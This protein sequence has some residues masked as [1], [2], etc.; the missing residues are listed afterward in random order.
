MLERIF[1]RERVKYLDEQ[2]V[3]VLSKMETTE[4]SSEEYQTLITHLER[5]TKLRHGNTPE[6]LSR[7]TM[8]IVGGN[9]LL[10]FG[11]YFFEQRHILPKV[12]PQPLRPKSNDLA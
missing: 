9:L 6:R 10:G 8:L 1:R 5:L 12:F 11:I 7:N 2:I 3:A 4:P